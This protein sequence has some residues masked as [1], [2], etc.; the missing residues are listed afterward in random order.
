MNVHRAPIRSLRQEYEDNKDRFA[1][2]HEVRVDADHP[3]RD[4]ES[5]PLVIIHIGP[6]HA[7]SKSGVRFPARELSQADIRIR[8]SR[9]RSSYTHL[10][11]S[12]IEAQLD[13]S[14]NKGGEHLSLF[15]NGIVEVISEG[16]AYVRKERLYISIESLST[17]IAENIALVQALLTAR[18]LG[19]SVFMIATYVD[20]DGAYFP[21]EFP[22]EPVGHSTVESPIIQFKRSVAEVEGSKVVDIPEHQ[23]KELLRPLYHSA[24]L[25]DFEHDIPEE[26][27]LPDVS[28]E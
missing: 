19:E 25:Q 16:F 20:F 7:L 9:S 18:D 24:E 11:S 13:P 3:V 10:S 28:I 8:G 23:I 5:R 4:G 1:A 27:E 17:A 6:R 2:F 22:D 15:E 14:P 12:G 26:V 21:M